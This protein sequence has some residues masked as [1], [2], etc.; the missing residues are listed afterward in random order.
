[1]TGRGSSPAKNGVIVIK[2]KGWSSERRRWKNIPLNWKSTIT[3]SKREAKKRFRSP[4]EFLIRIL[5]RNRVAWNLPRV[6]R[7]KAN[8]SY[9]KHSSPHHP[10]HPRYFHPYELFRPSHQFYLA[11]YL[12]AVYRR[13]GPHWDTP[14][15]PKVQKW[16]TRQGYTED[17]FKVWGKILTA[18]TAKRAANALLDGRIDGLAITMPVPAWVPCLLCRRNDFSA[19]AIRSLVVYTETH[20]G[21][22]QERIHSAFREPVSTDE[23]T[24]FLICIRLL[25]KARAIDPESI[26]PITNLIVSRINPSHIGTTRE[27]PR[28]RPISEERL[29]KRRLHLT[30]LYNRTL[31]LI[32][33]PT[34][35][36][37]YVSAAVQLRAQYDVLR[38]MS[39]YQPPMVITQMGYRAISRIQLAHVKTREERKWA[40][41]KSTSW[42]PWKEDRTAMDAEIG[43]EHG[44]SRAGQTIIRMHEAGYPAFGWDNIVKLYAGWDSDGSPVIQ[45][46]I[47]L[48]RIQNALVSALKEEELPRDFPCFRNVDH[49]VWAARLR[50]TRTVEESWAIFLAYEALTVRKPQLRM[51]VY[52]AL[53]ERIFGAKKVAFRSRKRPEKSESNNNQKK[54]ELPGD[55]REALPTPESPHERLDPRLQPPSLDEL[56]GRM[57]SKGIYPSNECVAFLVETTHKFSRGLDFIG[58]SR[59]RRVAALL[60]LVITEKQVKAVP[61]KVFNAYI[62]LL[63][64]HFPIPDKFH[65]TSTGS[66]PGDHRPLI[67]RAITLMDRKASRYRPGW[68]KILLAVHKFGTMQGGTGTT[69]LIR[70]ALKVM[71]RTGVELDA[72]GFQTVC[73]A[74]RFQAA[75]REDRLAQQQEESV[76]SVDD[77]LSQH[78]THNDTDSRF[79]RSIFNKLIGLDDLTRLRTYL[80]TAIYRD[81]APTVLDRHLLAVP[82]PAVLHDYIRA[83]GTMGDHEGLLSVAT[84]MHDHVAGLLLHCDNEINGLSRLRRAVVALRVFLERSW[85]QS[86]LAQDALSVLEEEPAGPGPLIE[87]APEELVALVREKVEGV[88]ASLGPWPGEDEVAEYVKTGRAHRSL[89]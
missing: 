50:T 38:R 47:I 15:E 64:R 21:V 11:K 16:V 53:F 66:G 63:C 83:L 6:V 60:E 25:R 46:R 12:K 72:E 79:L 27:E 14:I 22:G 68:N 70:Q 19:A 86:S 18:E 48:S 40:E 85:E 33:L 58:A 65:R 4:N 23:N 42:P 36:R 17:D 88:A 10:K 28:E 45:N 29:E 44:I 2:H 57:I 13:R 49:Q 87:P 73:L 89:R 1:M 31:E 43:P 26:Q 71:D 41:L 82:Q 30:M 39:E 74:F 84:F 52:L 61:D 78:L 34:S 77:A 37:P 81:G 51:P 62:T 35:L 9:V 59:D 76:I 67:H 3:G 7:G 54:E 69:E 20:L 8:L 24:F 5:R 55:R 56:Y 75:L 80:Q 32:S